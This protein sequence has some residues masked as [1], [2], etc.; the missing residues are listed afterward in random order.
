MKIC[1]WG[2]R[3]RDGVEGREYRDDKLCLEWLKLEVLVG[4]LGG[5]KWELET[6][7]WEN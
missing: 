4:P 2:I 1:T 3:S 5:Q 6:R 7:V